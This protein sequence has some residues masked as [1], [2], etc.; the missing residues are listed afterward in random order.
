MVCG[1]RVYFLHPSEDLAK[2]DRYGLLII[3]FL[4]A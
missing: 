1:I 2:T 4:S 3:F